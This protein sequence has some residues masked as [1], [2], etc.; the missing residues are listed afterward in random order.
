M[1]GP[2]SS[3]STI[4]TMAAEQLQITRRPAFYSTA[5]ILNDAVSRGREIKKE[6]IYK[7][8]SFFLHLYYKK[9]GKRQSEDTDTQR[10]QLRRNM[11]DDEIEEGMLVEEEAVQTQK[12]PEKSPYEMLQES[13][14]S[15]E[16]IVT[17]MLAI[18]QEKKPKSELRELVTQMFLNF[19]TLRQVLKLS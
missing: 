14:S 9:K 1:A 8:I 13:K 16:E 17:K 4:V 15:V 18:K 5:A 10:K 12:K 19:V 7:A 3:S 6:N 2:C 11:E